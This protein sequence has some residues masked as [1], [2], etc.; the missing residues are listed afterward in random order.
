ML[1]QLTLKIS[2]KLNIFLLKKSTGL[3][4]KNINDFV[5]EE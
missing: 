2:F 4:K 3:Y 5:I 1:R